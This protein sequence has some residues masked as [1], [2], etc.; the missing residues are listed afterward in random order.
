[1]SVS[2]EKDSVENPPPHGARTEAPP[3]SASAGM[4][5]ELAGLTHPGMVRLDNEDHYLIVRFGRTLEVVGSNVT[6]DLVPHRVAETGYGMVVADGVSGSAAGE[7]ASQLAVSTLVRLVLDTPD[8]MLQVGD[9][10]AQIVMERMAQRYRD[11][12]ATL[13]ETARDDP[14]LRGMGTTMTL[15][16]ILGTQMVL[17]HVGDSR[18]YLHRDR[19]LFRLSRDHTLAQGLADAGAIG[20]EEVAGHHL[21]HILIQ[22]LGSGSRIEPQVQQIYLAS[23]D[24]VLL[25]T[26]GLTEMVD[27][28]T[29]ETLLRGPG[30]VRD[31]CQALVEHALQRGGKDNVTVVL[32]RFAAVNADQ[33]A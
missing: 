6:E 29:I 26:D 13:A 27:E 4:K 16:C 28:V 21:R 12:N 9:R 23:G 3:R 7:T 18:A 31:V 32:A 24:Q 19:H 11:V 10:E 22:A 30:S 2:N 17:A 1:M 8:W 33:G 25:C 20:P 14:L 15:A 5:A